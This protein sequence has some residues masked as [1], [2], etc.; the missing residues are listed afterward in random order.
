MAEGK[1]LGR[2]LAPPQ[3]KN[4]ILIITTYYFF[5]FIPSADAYRTIYY[6]SHVIAHPQSLGH[7]LKLFLKFT[8][9]FGCYLMCIL[10]SPS[11]DC[12]ETIGVT[13]AHRLFLRHLGHVVGVKIARWLCLR[14]GVTIAT[15]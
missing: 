12:L 15:A 10:L 14:L 6:V 8:R 3:K 11:G 4:S 13:V 1:G 9:F 5:I 2:G 7:T